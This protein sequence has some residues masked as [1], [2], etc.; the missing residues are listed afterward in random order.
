MFSKA[1]FKQSCKANSV[2]WGIITFAVCFM[3]A[4]VMLISGNGNISKMTNGISE[5]II[6]SQIESEMDKRA[7]RYYDLSTNGLKKFDEYFVES[8]ADAGT[9]AMNYQTWSASKPKQEDY[10]GN[11]EG[12]NTALSTWMGSKPSPTNE[13]STAYNS[14][15][16]TWLSSQPNSQNFEST[17]EY[18]AALAAWNAK[19]PDPSTIAYKTAVDKL[20]IYVGTIIEGQGL[21]ADSTEAQEIQGVIF[22]VLNPGSQFENFYT[23]L[24]ESSPAYDMTTVNDEKRQDYINEYTRVNASIFLAGN[25]IKE[26]NIQNIIANLKDFGID[27]DKFNNITYEITVEGETKQVSR[28]TG[29]TGYKFI[30]NLSNNTLLTYQSRIDYAVSKGLQIDVA[31]KEIA[32]DLTS[33]F[34]STLPEDVSTGLEE[35]GKLD[36]YSMIVGSIFYKM[37]GLLLPIIYMIMV[38]NNL[39]AGQVDSG[40]MAYV[41]STSTKRRQVAF[42]QALFLVCS[43]LAMFVLTTITSVICLST[44][45]LASVDLTYSQL[46]LLNLGAF[47]TMFGMSGISF[48][49]SCWFNRSKYSMSI[50]GGLNMFFLVATMLGLFGSEALPSVVRLNSLNF[51]NYVS[52]ISL[53][54]V[55]SILAGTTTFIWKLI[56]LAGIGVVCYILGALKFEKKDLPL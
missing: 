55:S 56:I 48:L 13:A 32:G 1:L 35:L 39:I 7:I 41:L 4:C 3:L 16:E 9:F 31:K 20:G 52:I 23:A 17:E 45:D 34:L 33:S 24:G 22:Y 50:G 8:Y 44:L 43:L 14:A 49:A 6:K 25:M 26:E 18:N 19:K 36:L 15:L 53:F 37:A 2:M 51:F 12:Y 29:E 28:Y 21:A 42:T 11:E 27:E 46:I 40:S 54:D 47:C 38:A 10:S 30:N 5:T